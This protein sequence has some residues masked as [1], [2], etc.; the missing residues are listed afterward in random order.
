MQRQTRELASYVTASHFGHVVAIEVAY[1]R[2]PPALTLI[3]TFR[4]KSNCVHQRSSN[5]SVLTVFLC[6]YNR[7]LVAAF[8][9]C[10]TCHCFWPA[11]CLLCVDKFRAASCCARNHAPVQPVWSWLALGSPVQWLH[12]GRSVVILRVF[13]VQRR[14][15]WHEW[16][17][18]QHGAKKHIPWW[19]VTHNLQHRQIMCWGKQLVIFYKIQVSLYFTS[20][21]LLFLWL[22]LLWFITII[23]IF[24]LFA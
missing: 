14:G 6:A 11:L 18:C 7:R 9:A 1:F 3:N 22:H 19:P 24:I 4:R 21:S 20:W 23:L 12:A 16:L 17:S 8:A 15:I 5:T 10:G 13:A 2:L